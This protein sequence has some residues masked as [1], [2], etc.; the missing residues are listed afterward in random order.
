VLNSESYITMMLVLIV[1]A[2]A[3]FCAFLHKGAKLEGK[4]AASWFVFGVV[5]FLIF[6]NNIADPTVDLMQYI[7]ATLILLVCLY[8]LWR[9]LLLREKY[10]PFMPFLCIIY[11]IYFSLPVFAPFDVYYHYRHVP[12]QVQ[13]K[14]LSTVLGGTLAL[15]ITFYVLPAN[16]WAGMVPQPRL[17]GWSDRR[18]KNG[19]LSLS[20]L[21]LISYIV[22]NVLTVP[23]L[24]IA[25]LNFI[26]Q[27]SLL[28]ISILFYLQ[29][30]GKLP[31]RNMIFLWI[32][33][34]PLQFSL[35]V[36]SGLLYPLFR[37]GFMLLMLY[38]FTKK[39][40]PWGTAFIGVLISLLLLMVKADYRKT[41]VSDNDANPLV[42]S[43][44]YAKLASDFISARDPDIFL[45]GLG[46]I[47]N[48]CDN[49]ALM[50]FV[51][52]MTPDNVPYWGGQTYL[53]V[54]WRAIPRV[55]WPNK[56]EEVL[57]GEFGHRYG[58]LDPTDT[59]TSWNMPQIVE[60]YANFGVLGV[61]VGMSFIGV[62][63][64]LLRYILEN[65]QVDEWS[66]MTAVIIYTSLLEIDSNFSL[67]FGNIFYWLFLLHFLGRFIFRDR[68]SNTQQ[69][70][71]FR[72]RQQFF[73][74][75][76]R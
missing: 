70:S 43:S 18:A 47:V 32:L 58:V 9:Y 71:L 10:I 44:N 38:L 17:V 45:T 66:Q 29:L 4:K 3:L 53:G 69:T 7:L 23:M 39:R 46:N 22:P 31:H 54:L 76:A 2:S 28:A 11:A 61:I 63:Y 56:P 15:L 55:L 60:M 16:I 68:N 52:Y 74:Y 75:G 73:R 51:V 35:D 65:Q 50:A 27:L 26:N 20:V 30:Q 59:T 8:P 40:M 24:L 25:I 13:V 37:D 49:R 57:G 33:V 64:H 72:A 19:A 12:D 1:G 67:V 5:V 34:I 62:V 48:R 36:S 42:R 14:A 6:L 21:G 41:L